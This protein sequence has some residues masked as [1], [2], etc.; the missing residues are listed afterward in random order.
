LLTAVVPQTAR[1]SAFW[2][3]ITGA[4]QPGK[5]TNGSI[6]GTFVS[7]NFG[8]NGAQAV[9]PWQRGGDRP[10]EMSVDMAVRGAQVEAEQPGG[11]PN[12]AKQQFAVSFVNLACHKQD[13]GAKCEVRLMFD[14]SLIRKPGADWSA[15]KWSQHA[16]V[17][18]DRAQGGLPVIEG[19][20]GTSGDLT[21]P[22]G[23]RQAGLWRSNGAPTSHASFARQHFAAQ[24]TF[25][26][27][28]AALNLVA[29]RGHQQPATLF[30]ASWNDPQAWA[31]TALNVAQE[32]HS[33]SPSKPVFIAG[34]ISA[35][36]IGGI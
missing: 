28:T 11:K 29:Q 18:F 9:H 6:Q 31:I 1:S 16:R 36:Q 32:V 27:F 5:G 2:G 17:L 14:I 25:A 22:G 8:E 12:Q 33:V 10:V 26:Q 34:T 3:Q 24:M 35:I 15:M 13:A 19:P 7:W 30:G 21:S 23:P 20:L 4:G